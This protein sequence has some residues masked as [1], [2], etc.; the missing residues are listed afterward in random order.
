MKKL[1]F[2]F[3]VLL[4]SV[5]TTVFAE[6]RKEADK[7]EVVK[8]DAVKEF[9]LIPVPTKD[10]GYSN[11]QSMIIRSQQ[12]LDAVMEALGRKEMGWNNLAGFSKPIQGAAIDFNKEALVL[13][14]HTENSGAVEVAVEQPRMNGLV[15]VWSIK[16]KQASGVGTADMAYYGYSVVVLKEKVRQVQVF[17]DGK[18]G[19]VIPVLP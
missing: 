13:I 15:L 4:F 7:K 5:T 6:G 9:R 16:R 14:R 17:V 2:V 12:E 8:K 3:A 10:H 1:L 11:F 19:D 18:K